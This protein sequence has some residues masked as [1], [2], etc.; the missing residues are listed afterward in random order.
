MYQFLLAQKTKPRRND[1]YSGVRNNLNEFEIFMTDEEIK[2]MPVNP[3]KNLVKEKSVTASINYL[4]C[5]QSMA[6]KGG[7]I[8]YETLELQDYLNPYSNLS[9][10]EKQH[11]LVLLILL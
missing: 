4:K 5:K 6:E 2:N 8:R 3:F 9:L 10:K 1:W 11:I 7:Q